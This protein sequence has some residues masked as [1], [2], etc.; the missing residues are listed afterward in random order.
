MDRGPACA[1]RRVPPAGAA[2]SAPAAA[3]NRSPRFSEESRLLAAARLDQAEMVVGELGRDAAAGRPRQKAKLHQEWLVDVLDRLRVLRH[4]DRDSVESDRSALVLFDD[5]SKNP[6]VDCVETELIDLKHG[7]RVKSDPLVD[8]PLR[9]HLGE[10]ADASQQP[11]CHPR[12]ASRAAGDDAGDWVV[13]RDLQKS[14]RPHHDR[15]Q[16]VGAIEVERIDRPEAVAQR[17]RE[18][19]L[20]GRGPDDGET[21]QIQPEGLRPGSLA[22]DKVELEVLHCRVERFLDRPGQAMDLVDEEDVAVLQVGEDRG[23]RALVL[24]R[25][26]GRRADVDTHLVRYDVGERRLP[27]PGRPCDQDV[28]DRLV[29]AARRR[30]QDLQVR[31]DAILADE[32]GEATRAQAP[33]EFF[34]VAALLGGDDALAHPRSSPFRATVTSCSTE[35]LPPLPPLA[36]RT[37]SLAS[38]GVYPS[39]VSTCKACAI[40]SAPD[41]AGSR[42][43]SP[44][45]SSL[46]FPLS[47]RTTRAA[48]FGPMPGTVASKA[49]SSCRTARFNTRSSARLRIP[50]AALGPIPLTESRSLKN[51]NS[52]WLRKPKRPRA[53]S[54]TYV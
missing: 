20:P 5:G 2:R 37:A 29:A 43:S 13:N 11:V 53:S 17:R 33:F 1:P 47:S 14:G 42:A 39:P 22:A 44:K 36:F 15:E 21:R 48:V 26:A 27:Q 50:S 8:P 25:R 35:W 52:S 46:S 9:P 23:E 10:I 24:D 28:F 3:R 34:V 45:I 30:D 18:H 6:P 16:L 40:G 7:E 4:R 54:R 41:A 12:R 31:L 38:A 49:A 51:A 32:L 19:A